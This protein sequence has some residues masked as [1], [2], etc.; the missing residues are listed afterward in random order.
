ME[1]H[2]ISDGNREYLENIIDQPQFTDKL[3]HKIVSSRPCLG[4][5][6]VDENSTNKKKKRSKFGCTSLIDEI[7]GHKKKHFFFF[8]DSYNISVS[9]TLFQQT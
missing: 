5:V 6:P 8:K 1:V 4:Q 2:V 9:L 7:I 3:C